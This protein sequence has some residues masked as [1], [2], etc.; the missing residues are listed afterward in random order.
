MFIQPN[1]S[2][3]LALNS[4]E[5]SSLHLVV[6]RFDHWFEAV[7]LFHSHAGLNNIALRKKLARFEAIRLTFDQL[8]VRSI[9]F[10]VDRSD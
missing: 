8:P 1:E 2:T 9:F 4:T 3:K 10:V 7:K 5:L 6:N